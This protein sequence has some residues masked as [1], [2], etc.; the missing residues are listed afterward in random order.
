MYDNNPPEGGKR[1][2]KQ[3]AVWE[4]VKHL[5]DKTA[6]GV[7][8]DVKYTDVC[9]SPITVAEAGEVGAD[10][11]SDGNSLWFCNKLFSLSKTKNCCRSS[12]TSKHCA[13]FHGA[14]SWC[15]SQGLLSS[16]IG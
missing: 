2:S 13:H 1:M 5:K 7:V 9:A 3:N 10:V 4:V 6:D 12:Q 11:D 14:T 15:W 16:L 8:V